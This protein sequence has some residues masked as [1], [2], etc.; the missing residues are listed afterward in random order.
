M[1][2][3]VQHV[4]QISSST[5]L[6]FF[7]IGDTRA[8]IALHRPQGHGPQPPHPPSPPASPPVLQRERGRAAS[9][10]EGDQVP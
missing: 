2:H 9:G 5:G 7:R 8:H 10:G 3:R 4:Q 6:R 1:Y